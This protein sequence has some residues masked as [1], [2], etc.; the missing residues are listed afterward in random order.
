MEEQSREVATTK[1]P[2][3]PVT[4]QPEPLMV[5]PQYIQQ[6]K[7]SIALLQELAGDLAKSKG[8]AAAR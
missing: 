7:Q 1:R 4:R 6:A 5:T 2:T 3:Q 8:I